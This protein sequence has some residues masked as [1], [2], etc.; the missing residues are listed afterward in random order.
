MAWALPVALYLYI[1]R[2]IEVFQDRQSV[3]SEAQHTFVTV[4]RCALPFLQIDD[5]DAKCD[6]NNDSLKIIVVMQQK[7]WMRKESIV[8]CELNALILVADSFQIISFNIT[9][10]LYKFT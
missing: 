4:E 5:W 2:T 7:R 9:M 3:K 1:W 10:K 8:S 6:V